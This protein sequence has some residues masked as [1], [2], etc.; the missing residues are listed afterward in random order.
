MTHIRTLLHHVT[1]TLGIAGPAWRF[2]RKFS[3]RGRRWQQQSDHQHV[4]ML[5]LYRQFVPRG[6]LCFDIG[7]NVGDYTRT[8]LALGA[9][10]V[11]VEPQPELAAWIKAH[12]RYRNVVVVAAGLDEHEGEQTMLI[13]NVDSR[14]STMSPEFK[15]KLG[16]RDNRAFKSGWDTAIKVPVTTL[17]VLIFRYGLPAFTKI[18]VEGFE[19]QV[20][21]GLSQPLPALSLEFT[22]EHPK[23]T[24]QCIDHLMQLSSQ[25]EFNFCNDPAL[26]FASPQWLSADELNQALQA[27]T[28]EHTTKDIFARIKH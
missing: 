1:S 19:Y 25:Y 12:Y 14:I 5:P 26:G 27:F 13:H 24:F 11:A 6:S 10:V 21:R 7:A 9:R 20:I 8:F 28:G 15:D 17:D 23:P 3:A 4:V 2:Y 16:Q 22:S 18:D